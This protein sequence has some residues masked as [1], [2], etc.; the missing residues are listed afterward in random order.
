MCKIC[1]LR[2][3]LPLRS[4]FIL[5]PV[6]FKISPLNT[7]ATVDF[8]N[9]LNKLKNLLRPARKFEVWLHERKQT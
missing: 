2:K 9:G 3:D 6:Y 5:P 4:G 8:T 1:L 7:N